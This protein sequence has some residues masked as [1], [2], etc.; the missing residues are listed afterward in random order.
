LGMQLLGEIAMSHQ[1]RKESQFD[2]EN[3]CIENDLDEE[4]AGELPR[5]QATR[6]VECGC[7]RPEI[8]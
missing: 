6:P 3:A 7:C 8:T 2:K 1:V 5:G 4:R